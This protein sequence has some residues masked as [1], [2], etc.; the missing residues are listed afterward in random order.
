MPSR[1]AGLGARRLKE[2]VGCPRGAQAPDGQAIQDRWPGRAPSG[3]QVLD[4]PGP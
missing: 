1:D 4:E 3:T 2:L